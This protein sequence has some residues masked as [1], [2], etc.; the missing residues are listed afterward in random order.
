MA[1]RMSAPS[2]APGDPTTGGGSIA[3]V[4]GTGYDQDAFWFEQPAQPAP[5][6]E[7]VATDPQDG[8]VAQGPQPVTVDR[9]IDPRPRP[10]RERRPR[11]RSRTAVPAIIVPDPPEFSVTR[12]EAR[13][14]FERRAD[15]IAR[16]T[17]DRA[18]PA[19]PEARPD[20]VRP[21]PS[22][23]Q[24]AVAEP[25]APKP[26]PTAANPAAPDPAAA[27]PAAP[28]P[29]AANPAAPAPAA[30][31]AAPAKPGRAAS[32]WRRGEAERQPVMPVSAT[33]AVSAS[34]P[35]WGLTSEWALDTGEHL[36]AR[37]RRARRQAGDEESGS[38]WR[39]TWAPAGL[40]VA[41]ACSVLGVTGLPSI[42]HT[43][44]LRHATT[45]AVVRQD[46]DALGIVAVPA[47]SPYAMQTIPH[48]YLKLYV[49]VGNEY[50]LDWTMLAAVGQ[51][52]S[53]SGTSKLPGVASGT[54]SAGAAGPAQFESPTWQ[55]FGVD[56]D[57]RGYI[58]PYDPA[59]AITAMA[60]YLKA[61]GA[62]QNWNAALLTY[63]HSQQYASAVEALARRFNATGLAPTV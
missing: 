1:A 49:K 16:E 39:R 12:L 13:T 10:D 38:G 24:P 52:E 29:T 62:P 31:R 57:G 26:Q 5:G 27:N 41:G 55:R 9:K 28:G 20:P 43:G 58:S 22:D 17:T 34:S 56:A 54:N 35:S 6:A 21:V 50:G 44:A 46:S 42:G 63:N 32:E 59:D 40:L 2:I 53:H 33:V 45:A 19:P 30:S 48:R 15:A 51:I 47:P 23:P 37:A 60:A 4:T 8:K 36:A 11:H 3:P 7:Q 18:T 25:A 61:S 14:W